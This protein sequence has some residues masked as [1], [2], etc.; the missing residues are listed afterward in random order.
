MGMLTTIDPSPFKALFD[1]PRVSPTAL[2]VAPMPLA[3]APVWFVSDEDL[4]P[5]LTEEAAPES[6][7][8]S[9]RGFARLPEQ[10]SYAEF[11]GILPKPTPEP[12]SDPWNLARGLAT[13]AIVGILFAVLAYFAVTALVARY[14]P[15]NGNVSMI[16]PTPT[17]QPAAIEAATASPTAPRLA[18]KP[19]QFFPAALLALVNSKRFDP[20]NQVTKVPVKVK[21]QR[22]TIA[23]DG[24]Y[25]IDGKEIVESTAL[26]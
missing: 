8:V 21:S 10:D 18:S 4:Y 19:Q 2:N 13:S 14:G 23:P 25:L 24:G 7:T 16:E 1:A 5:S 3:T 11:R 17:A 6:V 22:V 12:Y 15:T 26:N 9:P 20:A